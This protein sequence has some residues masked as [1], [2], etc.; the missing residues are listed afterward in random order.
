MQTWT[1]TFSQTCLQTATLQVVG[2]STQTFLHTVTFLV[3]YSG[4]LTQTFLV[5][6]A[7]AQLVQ[8]KPVGERG[9]V[10]HRAYGDGAAR[11][12]NLDAGAVKT[13]SVR[14]VR[15]P[16]HASSSGRWRNYQ[17]HLHTIRRLAGDLTL[18]Y[19]G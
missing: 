12:V 11:H 18:R 2:V 10:A 7:G 4:Q 15:K 3:Q 19:S 16:L 5:R 13:A 8:P 1:D 9:V 14:Q 6:V 17:R